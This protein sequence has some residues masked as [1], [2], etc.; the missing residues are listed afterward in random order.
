MSLSPNHN[1]RPPGARVRLLMLH[2]TGMDSAAAAR[3]RLID[4]ASKVS[5]H[6]LVYEDGRIEQ[7]V[8]ENRRAWHA[9]HGAWG[10]FRDV[11]AASIGIE[12]VNPGHDGGSPPFARAQIVAVIRLARRIMA[13]WRLPPSAVVAHSDTAPDRKQDPG[14]RFPWRVC[15]AR[16]VGVQPRRPG[17]RAP[18][19]AAAA[20]RMLRAIGY[21]F[22]GRLGM[23]QALAAFQRRFRPRR[24]DGRLDGE[25]ALALARV[26][27]AAAA[28][29]DCPRRAK[30]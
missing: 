28:V 27:A 16:G 15:A 11:N 13:R 26:S 6:W 8:A 30:R 2:Y 24:V 20:A 23:A 19:G 12:I 29:R 3:A 1:A 21:R 7:L 9:G 5:A 4:P 18:H 17:V 14:E 22:D 10:A 25:T